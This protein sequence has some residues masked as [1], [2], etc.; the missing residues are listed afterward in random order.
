MEARDS[1]YPS[2]SATATVNIN[3]VRNNAAPTFVNIQNYDVTISEDKPV[4]ETILSVTAV[5]SDEGRNGDVTYSFDNVNTDAAT[6]F[7]INTVTGAIFARVSLIQAS[8]SVY[9]VSI[10]TLYHTIWTVNNLKKKPFE[11]I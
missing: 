2:R 3:V 6:I 1:G 11:N 10:L 7:G 9:T 4:L 5:D 8:L